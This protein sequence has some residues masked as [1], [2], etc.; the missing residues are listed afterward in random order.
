[1]IILSDIMYML[2]IDIVYHMDS[3]IQKQLP[4]PFVVYV[5]FE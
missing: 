2:K 1:M 5:D 3:A 4:A